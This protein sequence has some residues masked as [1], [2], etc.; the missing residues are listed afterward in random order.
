MKKNALYDFTWWEAA[1]AA[2]GFAMAIT[3]T[4]WNYFAEKQ[5]VGF[6]I[7][8]VVLTVLMLILV[9]RE[10]LCPVTLEEEGARRFRKFIPKMRLKQKLD[11]DRLVKEWDLI[12]TDPAWVTENLS[13]GE[14]EKRSFRIRYTVGNARRL[15]AYL[16]EEELKKPKKERTPSGRLGGFRRNR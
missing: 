3:V 2:F 4:F 8:G 13:A 12:L 10:V 6:L 16:G 1:L 15:A 7:A 14:I 11:Y 5:G 9:W